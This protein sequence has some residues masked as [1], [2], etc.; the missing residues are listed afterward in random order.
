[1]HDWP[2]TTTNTSNQNILL[3]CIIVY[4]YDRKNKPEEDTHVCA[5]QYWSMWMWL[6]THILKITLI[7]LR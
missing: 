4:V 1:M 3:L 7:K 2:V 6:G 5:D